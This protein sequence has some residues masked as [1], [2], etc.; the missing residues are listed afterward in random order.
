MLKCL[1]G[2]AY[3]GKISRPLKTRSNIHHHDTRNPVAVH[4]THASHSLLTLRYCST[5]LVQQ[6]CHRGDVD[7]MLPKREVFWINT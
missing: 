5:E 1:C 6:T 2:R 4:F 3:V 7:S